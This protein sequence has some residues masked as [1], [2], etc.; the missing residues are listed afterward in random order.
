MCTGGCG[1]CPCV[2]MCVGHMP[3]SGDCSLWETEKGVASLSLQQQP[4]PGLEPRPSDAGGGHLN[5]WAKCLPQA[6]GSPA[7]VCWVAGCKHSVARK[8]R[9]KAQQHPSALPHGNQD[10]WELPGGQPRPR[11]AQSCKVSASP[12]GHLHTVRLEWH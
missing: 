4:E 10:P 6:V 9:A 3:T 5:P 11:S 12:K 2:S 8:E 1:L 7:L